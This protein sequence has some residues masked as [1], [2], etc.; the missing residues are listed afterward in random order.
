MP[1]N[2]KIFSI[3]LNSN[4]PKNFKEFTETLVQNASDPSSIEILVHIN[5]NDNNMIELITNLNNKYNNIVKYI[6]TNLIKNYSDSWKPLNLLLK[7]TSPT[8]K[9]ISCMNDE[10]RIMSKNWDLL[11][12]KHL[13]IYKDDIFRIRC[14]KHRY[15]QYT[16]IWQCGY[17]PDGCCFYSKKW[18]DT[19]SEWNP[20]I[21]PDSYQECVSFYLNN[22]GQSFNRNIID[23]DI[24][25]EGEKVSEG[26]DI[27]ERIKRS[28][29]SYKAF[30]KLMS[31]KIQK[32]AN[33]AAYK[34]A[35]IINKTR[36]NQIKEKKIFYFDYLK[37][38]FLRRF[39]FFYHRG[40][41]NH[42]INTKLLNILFFL[43][44]YISIF[45]KYLIY[46]IYKL[47]EKKLLG[48]IITNEIRYKKIINFLNAHER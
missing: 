23:K 34:L 17:I 19:V 5:I 3:H 7:N 24:V 14:S 15:A 43:W 31:Y 46:L 29:I 35:N 32:R 12:K 48:K 30:F 1:V 4:R 2:E 33:S 37:I 6:E 47:K 25:L 11:L 8:V 27:Y 20:C 22:Y 26:L 45:D 28:K 9:L 18:L 13:G 44:C 36:H 21:G 41:P 38:N 39:N 10:I 42:I 40:S 16:D